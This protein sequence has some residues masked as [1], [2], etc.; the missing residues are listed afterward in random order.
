MVLVNALVIGAILLVGAKRRA[1]NSK[2][3]ARA[4]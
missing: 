4:A 2:V 3:L 1:S